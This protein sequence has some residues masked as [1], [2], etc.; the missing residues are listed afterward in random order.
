MDLN[1]IFKIA[2]LCK[3]CYYIIIS[4]NYCIKRKE[5]LSMISRAFLTFVR[6]ISYFN[7]NPIAFSLLLIAA[8]VS[9]I[10]YGSKKVGIVC[11]MISLYVF[12]KTFF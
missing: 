9:D 7:H 2:I 3:L 4:K 1:W 11:V 10:Y 6:V 5:G 12:A 8:G